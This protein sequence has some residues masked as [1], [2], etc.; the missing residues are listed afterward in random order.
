MIEKNVVSTHDS[1]DIASKINTLELNKENNT[2]VLT[3]ESIELAK[4]MIL[5]DG[6]VLLG[7]TLRVSLYKESNGTMSLNNLKLNKFLGLY[8]IRILF[9][10][11]LFFISVGLMIPL[12]RKELKVILSLIKLRKLPLKNLI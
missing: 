3:M 1:K 10:I 12:E 2:A 7:H 11:F 6:I 4:Q 9:I 8:F 5:I